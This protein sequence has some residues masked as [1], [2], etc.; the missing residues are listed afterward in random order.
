MYS[1]NNSSLYYTSWYK[2]MQCGT[3]VWLFWVWD[4]YFVCSQFSSNWAKKPPEDDMKCLD[5]PSCYP[6]QSNPKLLQHCLCISMDGSPQS[7]PKDQTPLK[8]CKRPPA[9]QLPQDI[10]TRASKIL[11]I[12][13]NKCINTHTSWIEYMLYL[14]LD[15]RSG[16]NTLTVCEL[17]NFCAIINTS[18]D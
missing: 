14:R 6:N 2:S 10:H 4:K 8:T 13:Q 17:A 15:V 3:K 11:F 18:V 16:C 1:I 7:A 5:A 12:S 9:K